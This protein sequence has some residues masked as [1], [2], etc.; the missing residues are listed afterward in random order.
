MFPLCVF[1]APE[2]KPVYCGYSYHRAVRPIAPSPGFDPRRVLSCSVLFLVL[3]P[4]CYGPCC[5][6]RKM[7]SGCSPCPVFIVLAQCFQ[8]EVFCLPFLPLV[9]SCMSFVWHSAAHSWGHF[10]LS[11]VAADSPRHRL[12]VHDCIVRSR[13]A[14]LCAVLCQCG[15]GELGKRRASRLRSSSQLHWV[16]VRV[17]NRARAASVSPRPP[18]LLPFLPLPTLLSPSP[19]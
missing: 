16:L 13:L 6:N 18:A 11:F 2:V 10:F 15:V 7:L 14:H 1:T 3:V 9:A 4:F 12:L 19:P 8:Q 5:F 17:H